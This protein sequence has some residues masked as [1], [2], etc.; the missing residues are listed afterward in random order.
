MKSLE[1]IHEIEIVENWEDS[2]CYLEERIKEFPLEKET[3]LRLIFI[4]WNLVL[5]DGCI[6][7]G[8]DYDELRRKFEELFVKTKS[9]FENDAEYLWSVGLMIDFYVKG[10]NDKEPFYFSLGKEMMRK[11]KEIKGK[12]VIKNCDKRGQFGIYFKDFVYEIYED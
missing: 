9:Y 12:D 2:V 1:E 10:V 8:L 5:E 3:V 7:H 11:G 6:K 4:Y